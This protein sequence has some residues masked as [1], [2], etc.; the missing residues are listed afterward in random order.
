MDGLIVKIG[1]QWSWAQE[2][3][4]TCGL[5]AMACRDERRGREA[6]FFL[7]VYKQLHSRVL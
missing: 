4:C 7:R 2:D 5:V 3:E 1:V 6:A